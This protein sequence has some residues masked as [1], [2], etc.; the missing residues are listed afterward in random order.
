M[1]SCKLQEAVDKT[2]E[3]EPWFGIEQEYTLLDMDDRPFGWPENGFPAPQ[4]PYCKY[5]I[6]KIVVFSIKI[7]R[8]LM[9]NVFFLSISK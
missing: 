7:P 8:K 6:E 2:G 3:H 9:Q 5:I 4:G 1:F